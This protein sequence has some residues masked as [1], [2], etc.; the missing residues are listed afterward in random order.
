MCLRQLPLG[1]HVFVENTDNLNTTL[2]VQPIQN[3]MAAL[4]VL[5]VA[6]T[7]LIAVLSQIRVFTQKM[8]ALIELMDAAE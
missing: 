4:G 1:Q 6:R 5:S 8:E 3:D 2:G 7:D